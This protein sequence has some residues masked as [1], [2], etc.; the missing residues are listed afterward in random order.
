MVGVGLQL[1]MDLMQPFVELRSELLH[2]LPIYAGNSIVGAD[3]SIRLVKVIQLSGF[4]ISR[5]VTH[6]TGQH[7]FACAKS[8]A[9]PSASSRHPVTRNALAYGFPSRWLGGEGLFQPSGAT[10]MP[11]AHERAAQSRA[12]LSHAVAPRLPTCLVHPGPEHSPM[13]PLGVARP[14]VMS[15]PSAY[16]PRLG[17]EWSCLCWRSPPGNYQWRHSCRN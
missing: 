8:H 12:A 6:L 11:G 13:Q 9:L 14:A 2:G 4:P 3:A 5:R 17:Q 1:Q 16:A 10:D 15:H 7:R